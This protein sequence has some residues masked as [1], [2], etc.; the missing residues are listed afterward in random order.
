MAAVLLDQPQG[1]GAGAE[2]DEVLAEH[3]HAQG[4]L[5]ELLGKAHRLPHAPQILAAGRARAHMGELGIL[6]RDRRPVIGAE[7]A[8]HASAGVAG[9]GHRAILRSGKRSPARRRGQSWAPGGP[10]RR[11]VPAVSR[12]PRASTRRRRGAPFP[13]A[14]SFRDVASGLERV[15]SRRVAVLRREQLSPRRRQPAPTSGSRAVPGDGIV[16]SL[17]VDSRRPPMAWLKVRQPAAP[18][19]ADAAGI[20]P[21][22][23]GVS[24]PGRLPGIRRTTTSR[25]SR[26]TRSASA[27]HLGMG[28]A[29]TPRQGSPSACVSAPF[30][31]PVSGAARRGGS[32]RSPA[33]RPVGPRSRIDRRP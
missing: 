28:G 29:K 9:C 7:R 14:L 8:A 24:L 18:E 26:P 33:T 12:D 20:V 17:L 10:A 19:P 6:R 27:L 25:R 30:G 21:E 13:S 11:P 3:A 15:A 23:R 22:R 5:A 1:A 4:H 16:M 2:Q 32:G 31:Q